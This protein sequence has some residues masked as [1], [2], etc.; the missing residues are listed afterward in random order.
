[1]SYF[2]VFKFHSEYKRLRMFN[3]VL[4]LLMKQYGIRT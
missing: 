3:S 1:M 2:R 4:C